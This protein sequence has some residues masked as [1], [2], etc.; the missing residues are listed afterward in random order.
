[1]TV[2]LVVGVGGSDDD[3]AEL[4]SLFEALVEDDELRAARKSLAA[5]AEQRGTLGAEEVIRIAVDSA[6]LCTALSTCV[7]AWLRMRRPTLRMTFTG[8]DGASAEI[9]ATG[10]RAVEHVQILEVIERVR[11]RVDGA[12]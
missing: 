8:P 6:A 5:A 10:T 9:D 12:S 11:G 7:V 4:H 1:M 3:V 2:E